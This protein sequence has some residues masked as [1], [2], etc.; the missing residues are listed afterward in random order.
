MPPKKSTV[1]PKAKPSSSSSQ[2]AVADHETADATTSGNPDVEPPSVPIERVD[3]SILLPSD[4]NPDTM[5]IDAPSSSTLPSDP[6]G[7]STA[8]IPR[9]PSPPLPNLRSERFPPEPE[10]DG[11]SSDDEVIA[12]L[13]IYLSPAIHPDLH[14]YQFPLQTRS[15]V[16]PTYARDRGK[17]ITARIKERAARIEVEIPV[18]AGSD[19]W[20]DDRARE[21]G[22]THDMGNGNGVVG[23]YGFGGR[24]GEDDDMN[25]GASSKKKKGKAKDEKRW[26]DKIRL[27]SEAVPS[28]TGYYAGVV[29]DGM[30]YSFFS[31]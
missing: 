7:P 20:R 17:G 16:A 13:P 21:L 31:A 11:D 29:Q 26:G 6:P 9:E 2:K 25:G 8:F 19:V 18:D 5:E 27:R 10:D 24:G 3:E 15:L 30:S 14:L 12:T 1:A 4:P 22:M 28:T 23:G